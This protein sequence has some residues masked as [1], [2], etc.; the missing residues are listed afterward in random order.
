MNENP[1]PDLGAYQMWIRIQKLIKMW[2]L[3]G[4]GNKTLNVTIFY[5]FSDGEKMTKFA[6]I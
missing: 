1:D 3:C 2:I 4:S 5:P 6:E